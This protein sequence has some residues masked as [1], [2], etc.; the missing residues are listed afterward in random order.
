MVIIKA[1]AS[2]IFCSMALTTNYDAQRYMDI[3]LLSTPEERYILPTKYKAAA[4]GLSEEEFNL[5][6]RVVEAESDRS[7]CEDGTTYGRTLIASVIFNRVNSDAWP[8][9]VTGVLTQSGQFSTVSNGW[10]S[11]SSTKASEW[12]IVEAYY[13]LLDDYIPSDLIYF[14]C[15]GYNNGRPYD[16]VGGNYFMYG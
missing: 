8:N 6:A 1:I 7:W 9:T 13:G 4:V 16:Y 11:I 14:N 2:V 12:A 15:I 10:C 5:L 3:W